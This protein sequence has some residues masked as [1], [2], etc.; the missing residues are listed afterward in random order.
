M[1]FTDL[2]NSECWLYIKLN[3]QHRF[4]PETRL[5]QLAMSL[6]NLA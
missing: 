1:T 3:A 4:L 6:I 2:F 5:A